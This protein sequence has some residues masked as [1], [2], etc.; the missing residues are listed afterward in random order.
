MMV[1]RI[2]WQ[3]WRLDPKEGEYTPV[4]FTVETSDEW[5]YDT[6]VATI[7]QPLLSTSGSESPDKGHAKGKMFSLLQVGFFE[8]RLLDLL[9]WLDL[10]CHAIA[11]ELRSLLGSVKLKMP[12]DTPDA[13]LLRSL[14]SIQSR[15]LDIYNIPTTWQKLA[16][17]DDSI[18]IRSANCR[19]LTALSLQSHSDIW[20]WFETQ[21]TKPAQHLAL[22]PIPQLIMID[23]IKMPDN[24]MPNTWIFPL[25]RSLQ[26]RHLS[27][28][29]RQFS[30]VA[31]KFFPGSTAPNYPVP[32]RNYDPIQHT[33][34]AVILWLQFRPRPGMTLHNSRALAT[35]ISVTC[36][37]FHGPTFL[38]LDYIQQSL[39]RFRP[40]TART[41]IPRINIKWEDL[42]Q[43]LC[44]HPLASPT[45][46]ESLI[47]EH[48]K[49]FLW[50]VSNFP[51]P[52]STEMSIKY[53][54]AVEVGGAAGAQIF[55]PYVEQ[56]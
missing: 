53:R 29:T 9:P 51:L 19:I 40:H 34:A 28:G 49:D 41:K 1:A 18:Q 23:P 52:R 17:V 42:F 7:D 15:T 25:F 30:L 36:K 26:T 31:N 6:S 12:G 5:I 38:Y 48:L 11:D 2:L 16:T 24:W 13:A 56:M 54:K 43:E 8:I 37:A 4:R 45:S 22:F 14:S 33:E 20:A 46:N 55:A 21:V 3:G 10:D 32:G 50:T 35:L 44:N 27:A 39:K 47:L